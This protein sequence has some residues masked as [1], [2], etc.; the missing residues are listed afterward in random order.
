MIDS[1]L[2]SLH[3]NI[4]I[5]DYN[6]PGYNMFMFLLIMFQRLGSPLS[7]HGHEVY[8]IS[9]QEQKNVDNDMR[10]D[11]SRDSIARIH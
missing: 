10:R 9:L 11:A 7:Y 2:R 1:G 8:I 5:I 6:H 4:P 3:W